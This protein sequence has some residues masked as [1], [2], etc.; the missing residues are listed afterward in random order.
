MKGTSSW[1]PRRITVIPI[2]SRMPKLESLRELDAVAVGIEDVDE[3]HLAGDLD[4]RA[5]LDALVTQA[6]GLG[7]DVRDVH[8]RHA[9][10]RVG[11][12]LRE[13]DVHFPVREGRPALVE[14]DRRLLEAEQAAVE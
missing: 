14:I 1:P 7:P 10:V 5:D 13:R 3:Q 2:G 6:G 9:R 11:V 8:H 4:D 12:A